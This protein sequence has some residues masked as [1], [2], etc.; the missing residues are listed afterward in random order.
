MSKSYINNM[1]LTKEELQE[2]TG[3]VRG[4][5]QSKALNAMG[6]CHKVRPNG[7]VAVLREHIQ[8]EFD[9]NENSVVMAKKA[10][11]NWGAING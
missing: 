1:F 8:K 7:E 9:G 10:E 2:L 6:I 4:H 3:L 11:P 5:A